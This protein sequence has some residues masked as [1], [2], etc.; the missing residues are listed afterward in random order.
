MIEKSIQ[1]VLQCFSLSL[2]L[3]HLTFFLVCYLE[4]EH[5]SYDVC[6]ALLDLAYWSDD[7]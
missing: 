6:L 5:N 2:S 7:E 1:L 3:L 4:K